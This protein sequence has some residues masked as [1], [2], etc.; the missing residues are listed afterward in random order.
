MK[1][2]NS[3]SMIAELPPKAVQAL[4]TTDYYL[5]S[6]PLRPNTD[7]LNHR[8]RRDSKWAEGIPYTLQSGDQRGTWS[9]VSSGPWPSQRCQVSNTVSGGER[10]VSRCGKQILQ[11]LSHSQG[12]L[13]SRSHVKA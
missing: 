6:P 1:C 10:E 12:M 4:L 5:S 9:R 11:Q 13:E 7:H 2:D 3:K 8:Y